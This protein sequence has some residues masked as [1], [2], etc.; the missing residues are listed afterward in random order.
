MARPV[1]RRGVAGAPAP[2]RRCQFDPAIM[3]NPEVR[4]SV[5]DGLV[6]K[7]LV[8]IAADR[9]G[10]R[11]GDKQLAEKIYSEPFFQVEGR[12][13]RERYEQIAKAEGLTPA[14]LDERL[15][16]NF[17]DQQFRGGIAGHTI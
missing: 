2:Q 1:G 17:R 4:R 13:N 16:Q 8:S 7:K 9:A 14:G 6:S 3:D 5:L 15:R 12:F 10:I 11:M